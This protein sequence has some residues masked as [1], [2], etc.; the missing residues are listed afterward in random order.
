[1]LPRLCYTVK[2]HVNYLKYFI[3]GYIIYLLSAIKIEVEKKRFSSSNKKDENEN[4]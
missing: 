2:F 4:K 3:A 1:M